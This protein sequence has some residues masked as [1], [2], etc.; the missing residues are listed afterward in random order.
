M[1][2][3][4]DY[5]RTSKRSPRRYLCSSPTTISPRRTFTGDRRADDERRESQRHRLARGP[6]QGARGA[7]ASRSLPGDAR[8]VQ[9]SLQNVWSP[10]RNLD[11]GEPLLD[12]G[13]VVELGNT[14]P[15]RLNFL[16]L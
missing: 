11:G 4:R 7:V 3:S 2:P 14:S 9:A 8:S 16:A 12:R 10:D 6:R 1:E 13:V 15:Q 5:D